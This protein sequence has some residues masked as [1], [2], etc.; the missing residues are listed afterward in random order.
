[1]YIENR[2]LW[3]LDSSNLKNLQADLSRLREEIKD[4]TISKNKLIEE[5]HARIVSL[6]NDLQ[7][8]RNEKEEKQTQSQ[9]EKT[10]LLSQIEQTR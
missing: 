6:E 4:I 3:F 7:Q 10:E 1:M 9:L 5:A 2:F 8:S